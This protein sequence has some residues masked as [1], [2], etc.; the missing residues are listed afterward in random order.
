MMLIDLIELNTDRSNADWIESNLL[1]AVELGLVNQGEP[2]EKSFLS[3][4]TTHNGF[5]QV[6]VMT[7]SVPF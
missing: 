2:A 5:E 4:A 3:A 7:C 6:F 1:N